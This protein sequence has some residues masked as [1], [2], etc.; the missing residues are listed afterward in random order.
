MTIKTQLTL[1]FTALVAVIL[2]VSSIGIYS[3]ARYQRADEFYNELLADAI[4]TAAIVL[5]SDNLSP[6]TLQPF[7]RQMFKT[8]PFE[9]IAIFNKQG[10]CVFHSGE[11]ILHLSEYEQ[12]QALKRGRYEVTASDT[13]IVVLSEYE[14]QQALKNGKFAITTGDTQKVVIP[15][16]DE[17]GNIPSTSAVTP[18]IADIPNIGNVEYILAVSSVDKIGLKALARL[19]HW[20]IGG[21]FSSLL[22]VFFAGI[23]FASRAMAPISGI[24]RKAERISA[25]DLSTRIS[26]GRNR[27][28]LF[29]LAH[30]FNGMLERLE[31]AFKSQKQFVAHASH[32]LRTPLTT[33][34]G[35]LDVSLLHSR[36]EEEYRGVIASALESTRQLNRLLNN[37]LVLAQTESESLKPLQI[38]E[39][40]FSALQD[41]KQRYAGRKVDLQFEVTPDQEKYL[42]VAGNEELLKI[43]IINVLENA[44]KFSDGRSTVTISVEI[45]KEERVIL[46]IKDAG[47]GISPEDLPMVFQ[48]FF[49]S[50]PSNE[51][52][53][54]GIGLTLVKAI[55][56]RHNGSA[57]IESV[58]GT[59]SVVQLS[60]PAI[61][62]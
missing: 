53:G 44:L 56:D 42:V 33:I 46:R 23:F 60:I 5:R 24:R 15:F 8:L 30:A 61:T 45:H 6:Q 38:D 14:H 26:E 12:R 18:P 41:V 40:L 49:R 31:A 58:Q 7:Q 43:A 32:E 16:L 2:A 3:Y 37:L 57:T 36:S 10:K 17:N 21:Y 39:V 22:L 11:Q 55:M 20:L 13:G 48:P 52:P 27:D 4:A 51:V 54:N 25:T 62:T 50:T 28:E 34:I 9:R 59:G 47:I 29:Q 19:R 35:Q 1:L